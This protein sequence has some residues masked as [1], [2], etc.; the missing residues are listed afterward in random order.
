MQG[1]DPTVF[2]RASPQ[3]P[4]AFFALPHG[5]AAAIAPVGPARAP[6]DPHLTHRNPGNGAVEITDVAPCRANFCRRLA[7][8]VWVV[9]TAIQDGAIFAVGG[10]GL[11]VVGRPIIQVRDQD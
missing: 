11:P 8:K 4:S 7:A 3:P 6:V 2:D 10:E 1:S 9:R 5:P